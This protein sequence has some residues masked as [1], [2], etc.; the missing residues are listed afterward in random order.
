MVGHQSEPIIAWSSEILDSMSSFEASMRLL[1]TQVTFS[2]LY[3]KCFLQPSKRCAIRCS[4][5]KHLPKSHGCCRHLVSKIPGGATGA[6]VS[7]GLIAKC[8]GVG[9]ALT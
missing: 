3:Q 8:T 9:A 6:E 4:Q 2:Q 5:L 7:T 1:L